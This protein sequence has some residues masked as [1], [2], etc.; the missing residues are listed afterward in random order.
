M[1][2]AQGD[3]LAF[4]LV[5][6]GISLEFSHSAIWDECDIYRLKV[7]RIVEMW[8]V[9]NTI[10]QIGVDGLPDQSAEKIKFQQR[11]K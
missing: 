4:Y 7:G 10:T 1:M 3:L 6:S 9:E 5:Y 8:G 11:E 2:C